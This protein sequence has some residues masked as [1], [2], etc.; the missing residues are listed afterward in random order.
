MPMR[1]L[2]RSPLSG[3]NYKTARAF[4]LSP[5]SPFT[6]GLGSRKYLLDNDAIDESAPP[7][8]AGACPPNRRMLVFQAN[9]VVQNCKVELNFA[10]VGAAPGCPVP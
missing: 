7:A 6:N 5:I 3:A 1:R 4:Q 9:F 2:N 8:N 10:N